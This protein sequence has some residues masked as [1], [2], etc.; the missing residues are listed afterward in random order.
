MENRC[1]SRAEKLDQLYSTGPYKMGCVDV[2][3]MPYLAAPLGRQDKVPAP[4]AIGRWLRRAGWMLSAAGAFLGARAPASLAAKL[5]C[6]VKEKEQ[7]RIACWII[8][9][10]L[11]LWVQ[12]WSVW[13]TKNTSS[14]PILLQVSF[15][16]PWEA[17]AILPLS[18]SYRRSDP[19]QTKLSRP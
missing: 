15:V 19:Q 11:L 3:H 14:R 5:K 10:R 17:Y 13:L 16:Y 4:R 1:W 7:G 18:R 2:L 8:V 12:P 9:V 6:G